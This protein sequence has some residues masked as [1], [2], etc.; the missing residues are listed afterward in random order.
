MGSPAG[1]GPAWLFCPADRP[2][3][4]AKAAARADV[5]ILD[6]EDAVG[7][8]AKPSARRAIAAAAGDLDPDRTIVRVNPAGTDDYR[9]DLEALGATPIWQFML[10]K[11]EAAADLDGFAELSSSAHDAGAVSVYAICETARG[12]I[13]AAAIAEAPLVAGL[14]WGPEDLGAS[15]GATQSLRLSGGRYRPVAEQARSTVLLAT[16]AFGKAAVDTVVLDFQDV[17]GLGYEAAEAAAA[18]F[19]AKACIHPSQVPVIRAAF[20]PTEQEIA[21]ATRLLAA[22]ATTAGVFAFEGRMVDEPVFRR[23]RR[24]VARTSIDSG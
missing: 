24:I 23:A 18:G 4:F 15:L 20:R 14:M 12:I 5:V 3:R 21:W 17:D 19:A 16:A 6:L 7:P 13:S 1:L 11:T 9:R 22:A 8:D 2:D 10:A